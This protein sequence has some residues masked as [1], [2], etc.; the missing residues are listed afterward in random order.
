[1]ALFSGRRRVHFREPS[2]LVTGPK[3]V[4]FVLVCAGVLWSAIE[5]T[6]ADDVY[7]HVVV[8]TDHPAASKAGLAIL[9]EDGSVV[10]AA[11]ASSFALSVCRPSSCGIGGGFMLIWD[12]QSQKTVALDY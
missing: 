12:A 9:R 7:T 4:N 8:A 2:R 3:F 11:I 10:D 5:R 6:S 1:M